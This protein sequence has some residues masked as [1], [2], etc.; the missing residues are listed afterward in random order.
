MKGLVLSGGGASGCFEA[1]VLYRL[2]YEKKFDKMIGTSVGALNA[3]LLGQAYLEQSPEV[4]KRVWTRNIRNNGSVFDLN[5]SNI[6]RL[7]P[8]VSF[9]PLSKLINDVADFKGILNMKEEITVTSVN[10]TSGRVVY[11]SNKNKYLKPDEF[12]KALISSASIPFFTMPVRLFG[13]VLVDGG[14]RENIPVKKMIKDNEIEEILVVLT[15]PLRSSPIDGNV[16]SFIN[17]FKTLDRMV[18][19]MMNDMGMDD[20]RN[21]KIFNDLVE[22]ID[23]DARKNI[24]WLAGKKL[25]KADVIMPDKAVINE[26]LDFRKDSLRD[27]FNK[28]VE[29]AERYLRKQGVKKSSI[30]YF[31]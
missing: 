6:L 23:E 29:H 20:F 2:F 24:P 27:G 25:V 1:G 22:Y 5:Y 16:V 13:K 8:P 18:E 12:R 26:T 31:A 10:L 19:L 28:G 3:V 4:I 17:P 15:R 11:T 14:V 7:R 30:S 9:K 21:I